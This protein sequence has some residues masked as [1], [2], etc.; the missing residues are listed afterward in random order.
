M[1]K[2]VISERFYKK[3]HSWRYERTVAVDDHRLLIDIKRNAYD[4]QSHAVVS[5]WS[6]SEWKTVVMLPI[7]LMS[8]QVVSYVHKEEQARRELFEQ[9]AD[10]L[11]VVKSII[12]VAQALDLSVTAEGVETSDQRQIMQELCCDFLQGY[13]YAK[14]L[15]S[16]ELASFV[17]GAGAS[18]VAAS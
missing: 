15:P 5:R 2:K 10:A 9:D 11:A 1:S 17:Q 14:P 12:A 4:E 6:G 18:G 8:C 3:S 7:E 13:L 16:S